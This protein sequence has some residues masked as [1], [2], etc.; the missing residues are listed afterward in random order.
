MGARPRADRKEKT[1]DN[2]GQASGA[3]YFVTNTNQAE[4]IMCS[5]FFPQ[6]VSDGILSYT[7]IE[8]DTCV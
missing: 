3:F 4:E 5:F 7:F 1:T 2:E 8:D 6:Y